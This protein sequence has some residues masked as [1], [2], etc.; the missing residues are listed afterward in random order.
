M[1]DY[2]TGNPVP[3]T[4][5]RDLDDNATVFDLLLNG[6]AASYP[7]RTG[8]NRKSWA[9]MEDDAA[10]LVSPNVAALA[11]VTPAVD[12]SVFFSATVPVTMGTYTLTSF[13]RTVLGTTDAALHRAAIGAVA[14]TDTGA[15]AGSAA[16]LTTSRSISLTGD[17]TWTVNFNGSANVTAALALAATGVS[18]GTYESVTVDVKGRVTSGTSLQTFTNLTLQNSWVVAG[19]RRA[20]V[21]RVQD[22]VQ[23]ELQITGGTATNGTLLATLPVGFRP[24]ISM[25]IPV[26]S[27]PNATLSSSV[28]PPYIAITPAGDITCNNCSSASG[29]F[30]VTLFSLL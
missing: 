27:G 8:I 24:T 21:R 15:F 29:I 18:A 9:Q 17:A 7:D 26:I 12:K 13:N 1:S 5:P 3:S 4:D 30:V 6:P 2:N 14:L 23:L 16:T 19:S 20:A 28:P 10:A 25:T 11:A 22:N